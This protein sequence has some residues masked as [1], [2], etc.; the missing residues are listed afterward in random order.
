MKRRWHPQT[1]LVVAA[2]ALTS[3]CDR[4]PPQPAITLV[5]AGQALIKDDPRQY[6]EAPF[7]SLRPIL[8]S[9]DVA[10]TNFRDGGEV[11]GRCV[12]PA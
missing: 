12:W 11:G 7:G 2:A 3:G 4:T 5:V 9:V 10:F 6:W 8:H 1:C